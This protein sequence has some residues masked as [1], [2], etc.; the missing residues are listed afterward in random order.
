MIHKLYIVLSD[1]QIQ[2]NKKNISSFAAS[3]A[4][5]LFLSMVPMVILICTIIPY[6]PLSEQNLVS[7]IT[8]VMPDMIDPLIIRIVSDVYDKSTG[9]LSIAAIATIWSAGK[10]VLALIRGLN[11]VNEVDEKRNYF[12]LRMVASFYTLIMLIVLILSLI[13]NVFGN[14]LLDMIYSSLPNTRMLFDF[15]MNFRFL[16]E[17]VILTILF[18]VV[19][20]V[21]PDK[22]LKFRFQIPGA[23]FS[24]VVWS[25]FSWCFSIYVEATK[26]YSIYGSLSFIIIIMLWMYFCIYIIL[27][28]AQINRYFGPTYRTLFFSKRKKH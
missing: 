24:A 11:E 15:I 28:G 25:V 22:K 21:L 17:W 18:T 5:F 8:E 13:L 14:V 27:I 20:A 3:I 6:T 26:N 9:V 19:Y 23:V 2:M 12:L 1:F 7:A 16:A 4:Y 10:G